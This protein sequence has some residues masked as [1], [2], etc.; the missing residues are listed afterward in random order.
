M[1]DDQAAA[2]AEASTGPHGFVVSYVRDLADPEIDAVVVVRCHDT[3]PQSV[4]ETV[5]ATGCMLDAQAGVLAVPVAAIEN[6]GLPLFT[7]ITGPGA[8]GAWDLLH[9]AWRDRTTEG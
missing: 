2:I 8:I 4:F 6:S 3:D 9:A 7:L 5:E 1:T